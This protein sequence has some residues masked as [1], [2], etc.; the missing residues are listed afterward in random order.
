MNRASKWLCAGLAGLGLVLLVGCEEK[1]TYE[2]YRMLQRGVDTHEDVEAVLGSKHLL[3]RSDREIV[4]QDNER[5]ITAN[6]EFDENGKLVRKLWSQAGGVIDEQGPEPAPGEEGVIH[7][8]TR[9]RT[10][11][12]P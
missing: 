9:V 8:E 11:T 2:R 5:A 10:Q 7:E 1:L 4:Y 3:Y 12:E 6:F